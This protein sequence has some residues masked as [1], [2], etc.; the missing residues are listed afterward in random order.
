MHNKPHTKEG[1]ENLKKA[2]IKRKE[3]GLDIPWNKG[4]KGVQPSTRK[5]IKF[6][7]RPRPKMRGHIPWN[8]GIIGEKSHFWKGGKSF[9]PYTTDWTKTL[10]RAIRER[11]HYTCQ[12]CEKESS[13][14]VHHIDY[15]KKNCNPENLITLCQSCHTKTNHNRNYW[16]NYFENL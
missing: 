1:R 6:P 12:I 2:W 16:I 9:E 7:Y 13:I 5:G 3:K 4:K 10:K 11:D 14:C 8:K 15:D